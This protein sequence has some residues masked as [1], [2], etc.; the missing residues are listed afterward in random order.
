MTVPRRY[1]AR[2]AMTDTMESIPPSDRYAGLVVF[3]VVQIILG[4]IC[5]LLTLAVATAAGAPASPGMPGKGPLAQAL[6]IYALFA[7]YFVWL[8]G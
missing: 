5:V 4:A 1:N 6:V 3:G 7:V 8:A 2:D